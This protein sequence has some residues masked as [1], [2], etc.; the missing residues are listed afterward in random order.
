MLL[1]HPTKVCQMR[2]ICEEHTLNENDIGISL[3]KH[4]HITHRAVRNV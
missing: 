4:R 3:A 2:V 1:L